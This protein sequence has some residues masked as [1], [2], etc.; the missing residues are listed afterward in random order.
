MI[1]LF[2]NLFSSRM[3][4][5]D[6]ARALAREGAEQRRER[7]KAVARQMRCETGLPDDP[8]LA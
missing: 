6:H 2:A 7:I 8:R 1:A 3:S 4:A 5:S